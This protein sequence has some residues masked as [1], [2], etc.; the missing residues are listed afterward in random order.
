MEYIIYD[1]FCEGL[2]EGLLVDLFGSDE[3]LMVK[4]VLVEVGLVK[5]DHGDL[6]IIVRSVV[7]DAFAEIVARGIDGDFVLLV[8]KVGAAALLVDGMEN[9]EVLAKG[10]KLVIGG[11]GVEFGEGS[12]DEAGTR[13]EVTGEA[14]GAHAATINGKIDARSEVVDRGA[15]GKGLIIVETEE[16]LREGRIVGEH[17]SGVIINMQAVVSGFDNDTRFTITNNPVK[18]GSW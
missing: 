16:L 13:R 10:G 6:V 3:W 17:T 11:N 9:V 12:A 18:L 7:T 5:V 4:S 1:I 2:N 14:D 8:A 15:S